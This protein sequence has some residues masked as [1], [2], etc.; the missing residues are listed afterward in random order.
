MRI[1]INGGAG[2]MAAA[3]GHDVLLV[4]AA[5]DLRRG[6]FVLDFWGSA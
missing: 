4:E 2:P 3:G 1:I 5:P 6:G